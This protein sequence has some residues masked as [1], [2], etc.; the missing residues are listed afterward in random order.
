[1]M[2]NEVYRESFTAPTA[3]IL[4]VDDTE[5][6]LTVVK[7]LLK[8]TKLIIDT[9]GGGE[10]ALRLL[11]K[12]DYDV[13]FLDHRMPVMDGIETLKAFRASDSPHNKSTPVISLTANAVSGAR[14]MYIKEGFTD[15]LT[16]PINSNQLEAML[17]K[18]LPPGKVKITVADKKKSSDSDLPNWLFGMR[19]LDVKAGI[20]NCGTSSDYLSTLK[21]FYES[22]PEMARDIQDAYDKNDWKNYTI[23]VHALKSSSRI[24]GA[25]KLSKLAEE[26]E[27]AG[28]NEDIRKIEKE[29]DN[30]LSLLISYKDKLAKLGTETSEPVSKKD[31]ISKTE[32]GH[33]YD[34]LKEFVPLMDFA[35]STLFRKSGR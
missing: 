28:N 25:R 31:P 11:S 26:L 12:R 30:L 10:E 14:E 9:A 5:M 27:Y 2:Q 34:A 8:Q 35:F 4:V 18:Y 15:Y 21:V 1:M 13:I 7:G 23:K 29:T 20:E 32:L 33:A 17:V 16:K 22:I 19:E 6:N 3:R 24:M